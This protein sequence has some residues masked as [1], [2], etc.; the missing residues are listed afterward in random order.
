V[1]Y[2]RLASLNGAIRGVM[3]CPFED[4]HPPSWLITYGLQGDLSEYDLREMW[5][6]AE[7][8]YRRKQLTKI[9]PNTESGSEAK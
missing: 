5:C 2:D 4:I 3:P 7:A 9:P 8:E 6:E 1:T